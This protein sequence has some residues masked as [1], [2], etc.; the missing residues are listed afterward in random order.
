MGRMGAGEA[1]PA[2]PLS[3]HGAGLGLH[4]EWGRAEQSEGRRGPLLGAIKP[5]AGKV[6]GC[7]CG[8]GQF[9]NF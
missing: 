2:G 1:S 8:M 9:E 6:K 3:A 7:L 4:R 5:C